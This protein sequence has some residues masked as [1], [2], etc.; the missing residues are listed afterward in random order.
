MSD[1]AK[2]RSTDEVKKV[3]AEQDALERVK[4]I[5]LDKKMLTEAELKAL[6]K[7]AKAVV[8]EAA[9]YAQNSPE[10]ELSELFTD[11]MA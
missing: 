9:A 3:R 1:P 5:L 11:V 6:D 8:G 7:D 2:Y 4:A 10:P